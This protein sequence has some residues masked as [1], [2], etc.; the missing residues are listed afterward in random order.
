MTPGLQRERT[1]LAWNRTAVAVVVVALLLVRSGL[2]TAQPALAVL[3]TVLLAA[4][5]GIVLFAE[6]RSRDERAAPHRAFALIAGVGTLA[7]AAG[8]ASILL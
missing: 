4:A 3:G 6:R 7:C 2:V 5:A 1:A 8:L